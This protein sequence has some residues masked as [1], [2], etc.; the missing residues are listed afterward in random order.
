MQK[1]QTIRHSGIELVDLSVSSAEFDGKL[2]AS[3]N[4]KEAQI[5]VN[6]EYV[7]EI[8]LGNGRRAH[9]LDLTIEMKAALDSETPTATV[10]VRGL[11]LSVQAGMTQEEIE[12]AVLSVGAARLYSY[13]G[14]VLTS[15]AE[16]GRLGAITLPLLAFSMGED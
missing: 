12:C 8:E 1:N 10:S 7:G 3:G 6:D 11:F 14:E 15:L 5:L 16:G 9:R 2:D 4:A 13:A